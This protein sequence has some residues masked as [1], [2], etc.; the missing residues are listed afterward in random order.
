MKA[1]HIVTIIAALTVLAAAGCTSS[2]SIPSQSV[3]ATSSVT[4]SIAPARDVKHEQASATAALLTAS[5]FPAG[6]A[7]S[8]DNTGTP[9]PVDKCASAAKDHR[10]TLVTGDTFS[11]GTAAGVAES[12]AVYDSA[13]SASAAIGVLNSLASCVADAVNQGKL[14]SVGLTVSNAKQGQLS[15][16]TMG[17][18]SAAIRVVVTAKDDKSGA[19]VPA[20][21]DV[22]WIISGRA[23]FSLVATSAVSPFDVDQLTSLAQKALARVQAQ[24]SITGA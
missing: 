7:A 14:N 4:K 17:D 16:P 6:W 21:I 5:D 2:S 22:I 24:P 19:T 3:T 9:S 20:Y 13:A 10:D 11:D 23:A 1:A 12:I 8:S 15:F 18:H